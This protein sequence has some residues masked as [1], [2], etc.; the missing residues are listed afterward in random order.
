[1]YWYDVLAIVFEMGLSVFI[2]WGIFHEDRLIAYERWLFP[3]VKR[4]VVRSIRIVLYRTRR[5]VKLFL[6][7]LLWPTPLVEKK[8]TRKPRYSNKR[9]EASSK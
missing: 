8:P 5:S 4:A 6:R 1:M 7:G 2:V 9:K 3:R